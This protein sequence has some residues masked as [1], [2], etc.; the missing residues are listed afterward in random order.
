[1]LQIDKL[2]T[3]HISRGK[4]RVVSEGLTASLAG[5]SVTALL[6]SNGV[7][8]ST[9][10]RTLAGYLPPLSGNVSWDGKQVGKIS[11]HEMSR[12]VAVVLTRTQRTGG[13]TVREVVRMGRLPYTG[14]SGRLTESDAVVAEMMMERV[15]V[16]PLAARLVDSLSDG[17]RQRVMIA[18]ALAQATPAI[19]LD[20]PFAFLDFPGKVA[21]LRL[22]CRLAHEDGKLILFSTHDIEISLQMVQNVWILSR[23]GLLSGTPAAL[24]SDGSI[25]RHFCADALRFDAATMRFV[26]L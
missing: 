5:G 2:S 13:M 24:A 4:K 9:L 22:L 21:M 18:K 20:E 14:F 19:L 25:E 26:L 3:G 15:G 1:M 17:E 7:G 10:L 16:A 11:L 6:G 12:R 23:D 8:K